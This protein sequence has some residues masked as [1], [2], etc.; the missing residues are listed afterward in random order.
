MERTEEQILTRAPIAIVLGGTEYKIPVLTIA[1]AIDWRQKLI[2]TAEDITRPL[3]R[4]IKEPLWKRA[5]NL[6]CFWRPR[7]NPI[8]A[9]FAGLGTA[10]IAFPEK[11]VRLIFEYAPEL[12]QKKIMETATEEEMFVAFSTIVSVVNPLQRQISLMNSVMAG[13]PSPS[14]KPTSSFSPSTASS[15]AG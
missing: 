3:M 15:Q 13:I 11:V 8:D 10:F 5:W 1:K 14:A 12:P 7:Q 4:P 6:L 2:R 9:I